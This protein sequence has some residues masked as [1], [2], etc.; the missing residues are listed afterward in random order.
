MPQSQHVFLVAI[1]GPSLLG[2][3]SIAQELH[4][5]LPNAKIVHQDDF[6]F[7]E[8]QLPIDEATGYKNWDCSE[9]IDFLRFNNYLALVKANTLDQIDSIVSREPRLQLRL[10][11]S[12]TLALACKVN[13]LVMMAAIR[14]LPDRVLLVDGFM[15]FHD[16]KV[17][18]LFDLRIFVYADKKTL[19]KR[20]TERGAYLT[21]CGEWND[22]PEYFEKI[23]WPLYVKS[24]GDFFNG[25]DPNRTVNDAVCRERNVVALQSDNDT[26]LLQLV[27]SSLDAILTRLLVRHTITSEQC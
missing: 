19:Y 18:S 10:D 11:E 14:D 8:N 9:A 6:F 23:V 17:S 12:A 16:S 26:L 24:H 22:P 25:N 21:D 13:V 1:G 20:R 15:L 5:L 4:N 27:E 2:K 7:P 3:T